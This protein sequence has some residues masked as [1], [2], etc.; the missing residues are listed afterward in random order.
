MATSGLVT[1]NYTCGDLIKSAMQSIG[2][3]GGGETPI[4]GDYEDCLRKLNFLIQGWKAK[5]IGL[6]LRREATLFLGK[7]QKGYK[8]GPTG[9]HCTLS[10]S[11][12]TTSAAAASGASTITVTDDYTLVDLDGVCLSQSAAS[13]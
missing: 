7:G 3:L 9:D 10:F 13:A 11:T 5:G 8:I 4:A 1:C 2:A 6:W 12:G